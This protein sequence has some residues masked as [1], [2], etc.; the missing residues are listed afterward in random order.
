MNSYLLYIII[1]ALAF[2][3]LYLLRLVYL[4]YRLNRKQKRQM[5][6][7]KHLEQRA[8]KFLRKKGFKKIAAQKPHT[9]ALLI[10]GQKRSIK[11]IPDFIAYKRGKL[12][13]IEVKSGKYAPSI[14]NESTRRQLLEYKHA[15]NP[16]KVYLLDMSKEKIMEITF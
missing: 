13:V 7:G 10:D 1:A 9:Y 14:H 4:Q 15:L 12:C 5:R 3:A 6:L 16:D 2:L 11:I 8:E